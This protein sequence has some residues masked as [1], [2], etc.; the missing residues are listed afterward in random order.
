MIEVTKVKTYLTINET[1][2]SLLV[3]RP[4]ISIIEVAK[5]GPAGPPGPQG[6]AG[7]GLAALQDDPNPTLGGNLN[8]NGFQIIGQVDD[9]GLIIDGGLV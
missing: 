3:E 7:S 5:Q 1:G 4:R 2:T 6:P 9:T 8:L